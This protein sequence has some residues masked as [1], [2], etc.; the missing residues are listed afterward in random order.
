MNRFVE[1]GEADAWHRRNAAHLAQ[2]DIDSDIV[3]QVIDSSGIHPT[4]I[5]DLGCSSGERLEALCERY[6]A[7]GTGIDASHDAI[8]AAQH[9]R[10]TP[11]WCAWDWT[12]GDWGL[13][14]LVIVS[15]TLHWVDRRNLMR[16]LCT[17]DSCLGLG[18]N[19]LINDFSHND[20]V[21]YKHAPGITTYKRL[22]HEIFTTTRMYVP[23]QQKFYPYPGTNEPCAATLLRRVE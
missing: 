3:A 18:G 11:R 12:D 22:Y 20:D 6:G 14:D 9:R 10:G 16:A 2:Y 15:Y 1:A 19:L 4:S 5:L 23:I 7:A 8:K 21:P 17:I 13:F